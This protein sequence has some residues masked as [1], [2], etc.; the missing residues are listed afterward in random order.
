LTPFEQ[1]LAAL[2]PLPG[3]LDRDRLMFEAGRS[4]V[5]RGGW[6]WPYATAALV[7]ICTALGGMMLL[8]R[9][10]RIVERIVY[11]PL[12]PG[13]SQSVATNPPQTV[14]SDE[15]MVARASQEDWPPQ[16]GYLSVRQQVLRWG[17]DALPI[18]PVSSAAE[19][20]LTVERLLGNPASL[21]SGP[22]SKPG[23]RL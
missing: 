15:A 6:M 21:R 4:T 3:A 9:S 1:A 16:P 2:Q 13:E 7:L 18:P 11:I 17:A 8:Q 10:S 20:P 19:P 14:P 5:P 22:T 23:D 12:S